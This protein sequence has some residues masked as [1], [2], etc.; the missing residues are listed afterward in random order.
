MAN[1]FA[2]APQN[3]DGTIDQHWSGYTADEHDR[4]DR[5]YAASRSVL[6]TRACAQFLDALE[7]LDLSQ[8]GIPDMAE[9]SDRL[10]PLTG[11]SVVPVAG[12]VS[13][14]AFFD[15]LANRR[16]PAGAFIRSEAEMEYLEEPD[17]FHDI[18]GHV[19]LL[20]DPTYAA[21]LEAYGKGGARAMERGMLKQLARLYW[22]T[23]EFGLIHTDHGLRLFGAGIM[24]STAESKFAL[25]DPSP[26][27]VAFDLERVMRTDYL[28]DDFQQTYFVIDSFEALLEASYQDFGALY[29]RLDNASVIAPSALLD[30]DAVLNR[31]SLD[32]FAAKASIAS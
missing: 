2:D 3:A 19:P 23:V 20:A 31:G 24:S 18:F 16:F 8:G 10:R 25:E 14:E 9:L 7:M 12:L 21:Y 1:R 13:D 17:I 32:Y 26:H 27:R 28:I 22:Y 5:L 4:W 30:C 6:E 11:W 15:H 29:D